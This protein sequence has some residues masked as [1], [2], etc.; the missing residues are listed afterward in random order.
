MVLA[1]DTLLKEKPEPTK[2]EIQDALSG[3]LCRCT[4]Y[5]QI[6]H[7]VELS[8]RELRDTEDSTHTPPEFREDLVW[9]GK[10]R[11]KVDG[12]KLVRGEKAFVEDFVEPGSYHLVM[13]RSPF[14][15]AYIKD[16]DTSAAEAL[17]GVA[18]VITYRNSP[19]LPY[20]QAGQGFPEPSP[21][22]RNMFGRKLRHVGDR[23]AAVVAESVETARQA[24]SLIKV[25]YEPLKPIFTVEE[26][27]KPGAPL[28]HAGSYRIQGEG[29]PPESPWNP[30]PREGTILYQFSIGA[31]PLKNIAASVTGGIG[32]LE[33][34]FNQDRKSV[35]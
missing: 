6:F 13:L 2:E 14:A 31:E 26:A 5:Q 33:K 35:V 12:S 3:I 17:P 24:I 8:S 28:V 32:D 34:G 27:L 23:V 1:L 30:D 25:S 10:N 29:P 11:G 16:L 7:A 21:Y 9:I 15:S 4:G 22:D 20:N 18:A 19:D